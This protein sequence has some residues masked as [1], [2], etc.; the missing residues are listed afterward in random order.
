M[1]DGDG[2]TVLLFLLLWLLLDT[3]YAMDGGEWILILT[4]SIIINQ[5]MRLGLRLRLRLGIGAGVKYDHGRTV[6]ATWLDITQRER[7]ESSKVNCWN[8][9]TLMERGEGEPEKRCEAMAVKDRRGR[10]SGSIVISRIRV[11]NRG[12]SSSSNSHHSQLW[13]S[14]MVLVRV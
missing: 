9:S 11:S 7:L 8:S 3:H 13:C 14:W 6:A 10:S 4:W 1:W 12:N 5:S 2:S